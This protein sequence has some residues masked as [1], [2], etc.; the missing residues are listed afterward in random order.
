MPP[1]P[2]TQV[3]QLQ[4]KCAELEQLEAEREQLLKV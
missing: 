2:S 3:T 1:S 4:Q